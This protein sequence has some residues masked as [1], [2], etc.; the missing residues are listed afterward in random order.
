M[1]IELIEQRL[2]E[3]NQPKYRLNQILKA[4]FQDNIFDF[5]KIVNI[6]KDLKENLNDISIIDKIYNDKDTKYIS[7]L[8]NKITEED[9][10]IVLF[11]YLKDTFLDKKEPE[12]E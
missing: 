6:P 2:I 9:N 11:K 10:K 8:A 7:K 1:N 3:L 12:N 5:N 4:I